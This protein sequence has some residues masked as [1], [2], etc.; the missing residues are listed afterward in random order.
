[1]SQSYLSGTGDVPLRYRTIGEAFDETVARHTDRLALVVRHQRL[2]LT[3]RDLAERV[4]RCAAGFVALGLEP[5]DRIGICA[6]NCVEWVVTQFA[7]AKAG[8]ILVT[9]NPAYRATELAHA[10]RLAGV[11]ALVIAERLKTSDYIALLE[12]AAPEIATA[13]S[14]PLRLE[15]FPLLEFIIQIGTPRYP[16]LLGFDQVAVAV[17]PWRAELDRRAELMTPDDPINIQFTSGT[18]GAPKGA[19]L[20]HHNILTNGFFVARGMALTSDDALCIPVPL[21]HCFGMVMGV[22]GCLTHGAAMIFPDAGF[23]AQATLAAIAEERCTALFGVPTMFIAMLAHPGFD[24]A[25][26]TSLRTG[27]MA[28]ASCPVETMRQVIE[29][30]HMR[31]ITIC[32]GMTETSPVSFQTRIDDDAETRVATV[33]RILP[34]LEAKLVDEVGRIV[35]IGATG[36]LLVRGYS[37]MRG[38]W[39]QPEATAAAIDAGGWMHSGDLA[40][41]GADGTCR[42]VGRLKDM[43][44]R[45]GENIYPAEVENFLMT[46]PDIID[47]AI[48]GIPHERLGEQVV[49]WLRTARAI[50]AEELSAFCRDRIAHYKIPSVVRCVEHFPLTVTGKVQKFE[51]R[52][53]MAR[54]V[55]RPESGTTEGAEA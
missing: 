31:D 25:R 18:T 16:A 20:T 29:Q 35:P 33:G 34:W 10:L 21:Y 14:A 23:D 17:A 47:V 9:I 1:M 7:S 13:D 22:L 37:V 8:L 12:S 36:E 43:I 48:F 24:T 40:V 38:Y 5:G 46:H 49:A 11:R 51:M 19:T 44:I 4:D 42:I 54:E 15:A 30:M 53:A 26:L 41:F 3:W 50:D 27:V 28:G 2:R 32:Y 52:N 6:P 39:Q 45:G 55:G